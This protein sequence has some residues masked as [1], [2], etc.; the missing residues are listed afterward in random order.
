M[1]WAFK[2]YAQLPADQLVVGGLPACTLC[3]PARTLRCPAPASAWHALH[4]CTHPACWRRLRCVSR[5]G[6]MITDRRALH[7]HAPPQATP[8]GKAPEAD[9]FSMW[10]PSEAAMSSWVAAAGPRPDAPAAGLTTP[11][12]T[13][14]NSIFV[15]MPGAPGNSMAAGMPTPRGSAAAETAHA[16]AAAAMAAGLPWVWELMQQLMGGPGAGPAAP[17]TAAA[18][19]AAAAPALGP[20]GSAIQAGVEAL[21]ARN[22]TSS[23][24]GAAGGLAAARG[25]SL[26]GQ[27]AGQGSSSGGVTFDFEGHQAGLPGVVRVRQPSGVGAALHTN[28]LYHYPGSQYAAASE[29]CLSGRCVRACMLIHVSGHTALSMPPPPLLPPHSASRLAA[30]CL[31]DRK[32]ASL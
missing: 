26:S 24:A 17:W 16:A 6:T 21:A 10:R 7:L 15:G 13:P 4:P 30:A 3:C 5:R 2:V 9:I 32:C 29:V 20:Q 12:T 11:P 8:V 1:R 31:L 28:P 25:Q 22:A 19:A 23:M 18:A 14:A 27:P